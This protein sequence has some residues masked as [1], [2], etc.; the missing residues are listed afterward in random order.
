MK[1]IK[2]KKTN[3]IHRRKKDKENF[4]EFFGNTVSHS[5]IGQKNL[6]RKF[7]LGKS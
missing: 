5:S 6:H 2:K 4:T 3:Q 1:S 7:F